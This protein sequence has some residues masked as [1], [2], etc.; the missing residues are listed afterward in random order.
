MNWR[1]NASLMLAGLNHV[2][3]LG[4]A[5][6]E[7]KDKL[8]Q[9]LKD[10][11]VDPSAK[12]TQAILNKYKEIFKVYWDGSAQWAEFANDETIAQWEQGDAAKLSVNSNGALKVSSGGNAWGV[13]NSLGKVILATGLLSRTNYKLASV[14]IHEMRH[15]IF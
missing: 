12:P 8:T 11:E 14:F 10:S 13:T 6:I 15:S 5:A 3:H 4:A 2:A 1:V 7:Y 9:F